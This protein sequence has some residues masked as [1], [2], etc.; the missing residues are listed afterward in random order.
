M[1][2][3]PASRIDEKYIF[4]FD[5]LSTIYGA[6]CVQYR[7]IAKDLKSSNDAPVALVLLLNDEKNN[8][9]KLIESIGKI[10]KKTFAEEDV[11]QKWANI[12]N[13][14]KCFQ[15]DKEEIERMK[16]DGVVI[17]YNHSDDL[18]EFEGFLNEEFS[19]FGGATIDIGLDFWIKS[20]WSDSGPIP[21]EITTNKNHESFIIKNDNNPFCKGL[22]IY[23]HEIK[24]KNI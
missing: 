24:F 19:C 8:L 14:R 9:L 3:I 16:E 7:R 4:N 23:G 18:L 6:L 5:E 11:L 15:V 20:T 10:L 13:N 12:F 22:V 2:V 21:W 1:E 17:V